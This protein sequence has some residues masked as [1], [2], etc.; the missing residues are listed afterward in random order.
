MGFISIR[1]NISRYHEVVGVE[2]S[3]KDSETREPSPTFA[4]KSN[5]FKNLARAKPC[6]TKN[7]SEHLS[8]VNE[9]QQFSP[10]VLN[11]ISVLTPEDHISAEKN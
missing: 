10:N 8:P 3:N 7:S 6:Q 2:I 5:I 4:R 9:S 11:Y 1:F